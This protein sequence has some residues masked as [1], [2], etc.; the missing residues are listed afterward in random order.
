M[1]TL[2]RLAGGLAALALL[3]WGSAPADDLAD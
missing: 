1:R 2:T 3:S